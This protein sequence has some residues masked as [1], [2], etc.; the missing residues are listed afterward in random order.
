M[1]IDAELSLR[2]VTLLVTVCPTG[3]A[4]NV[5]ASGAT[6]NRP[7]VDPFTTY[8]HPESAVTTRQHNAIA[9]NPVPEPLSLR[10]GLRLQALCN[11][12]TNVTSVKLQVSEADKKKKL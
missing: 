3:T 10:S 7:V 1:S 9:N 6:W 2:R 8:P 12:N 4:P 5:S 11:L